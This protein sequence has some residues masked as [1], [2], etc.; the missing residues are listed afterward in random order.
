MKNLTSAVYLCMSASVRAIGNSQFE[1]RKGE[2]RSQCSLQ[3]IFGKC[4]L[5]RVKHMT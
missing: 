2:V 3:Y 1:V 5:S 4:F